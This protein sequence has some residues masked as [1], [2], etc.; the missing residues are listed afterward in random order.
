M[1]SSIDSLLSQN[2]TAIVERW[3]TSIL[4]SY[5]AET[6][7]FLARQ[8]DPIANPV[9]QTFARE[10]GPVFDA[11]L[12]SPEVERAAIEP[13]LD[14][15]VRIRAVQDYT[16]SDAL[17]FVFELKR[18]VRAE[19]AGAPEAQEQAAAL[20][21]FDGRVD[22][23]ALIAFEI[24]LGCKKKMY[25]IRVDEMKRQTNKLLERMNRVPR[26]EAGEG[27]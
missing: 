19:L 8:R 20:L 5:P 3:L 2:K 10:L 23:L 13:H 15:I 12:A 16:A 11:L 7:R 17:A 1:H 14:P 9:G 25:E 24:Y 6:S 21:E 27:E 18:V 26:R 22:K 4:E